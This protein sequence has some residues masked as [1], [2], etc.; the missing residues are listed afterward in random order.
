M[1]Q[2]KLVSRRVLPGPADTS[3]WD[4]EPGVPSIAADMQAAGVA[5]EHADKSPGSRK[6]GWLQLRKRLQDGQKDLPR[7]EP[8]L[9]VFRSCHHWLDLVPV[10]PR[11]DKDLDDVD[12]DAEDHLGDETRYR[13]RAAKKAMRQGQF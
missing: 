12:T 3:I 8:G 1:Q 11:D 4:S 13:V 10:L 2:I 7:E 6:Q 9:F 5:W